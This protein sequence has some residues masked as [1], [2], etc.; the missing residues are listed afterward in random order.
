MK[1]YVVGTPIGNLSDMSPRA[2][3]TLRTVDFIA[4]EDTRVTVKLLNHFDIKKPMISYYE[5][6]LRE[7]GEIIINRILAGESCAVV[8]DAGM[9]CISDPGEDLVRLCAE[10]GIEVAVVPGPSAAI[11]ALAVS[12]LVTSRFSFEGFLSTSRKA[13]FEHLE[14]VKTNPRTLIFYEAPHKLQA[15]L[16]DMLNT[17]G[18]RKI[19]LAREL[20]KVYEEVRR[21]T[22]SEAIAFY[23]QNPPRGEFVLIIEGAPKQALTQET[24][25]EEAAEIAKRLME[26]GVPPSEAAKRVSKQTGFKRSEIYT[27]MIEKAEE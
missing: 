6:N 14:E 5:H 11:S 21:T 8:T 2:I 17:F 10:N 20:T 4:A 25:L 7:R 19:T 23:E 12:G 15:T 26:E 27:R 1:L 3:E 13:R 16:A 18:N 9:P 22:L 24:T